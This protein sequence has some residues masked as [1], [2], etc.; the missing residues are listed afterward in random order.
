[1]HESER[2]MHESEVLEG[3]KLPL[4]QVLPAVSGWENAGKFGFAGIFAMARR[5][6]RR[7]HA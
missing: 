2:T 7:W 5:L 1:M 6:L 3:K 4:R